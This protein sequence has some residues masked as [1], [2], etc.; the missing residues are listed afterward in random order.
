MKKYLLLFYLSASALISHGQDFKD[1][2]SLNV[3]SGITDIGAIYKLGFQKPL[4]EKFAIKPTLYIDVSKQNLSSLVN[5]GLDL[6]GQL[7]V[8]ALGE[9]ANLYIGIGPTAFLST[10]NKL[11][12]PITKDKP[13]NFYF[14]GV[15]ELELEFNLSEEVKI[16][17][18]GNQRF[19]FGPTY[20]NR[21]YDISAGL[22]LYIFNY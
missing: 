8:A 2:Y 21:W 5:V 15:G 14:G 6:K 12:Q 18:E 4:N 7:F 19:I 10:K 20:G 9:S 17:I 1:L 3:H 13:K 11:H 22:K 16:S